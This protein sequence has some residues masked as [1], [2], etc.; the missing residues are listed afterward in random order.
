MSTVRLAMLFLALG[1]AFL[2]CSLESAISADEPERKINP[3]VYRPPARP[4]LPAVRAAAWAA[5][6][7]DC[8]ILAKLEAQGLAPSPRADKRTL[9]RRVTVDLTGLP[10]TA[11]EQEEFLAD[12][13]PDAYERVVDRLLSSPRYGERWAQHWLDL[14]R[15]AE[16][17][18]FKAD[19]LRLNAFRYRD[20]VIRALNAD[21][22]YDRFLRQQLAGDELEPGN[23]DAIVATGYNRLWPDEYNSATLELRHQVFARAHGCE[24]GLETEIVLLRKWIELVIVA[25]RAAHGQPQK[26]QPGHFRHV[27][28][29]LLMAQ[30]QRRGVVFIGP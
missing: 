3:W 8:F 11:A 26:R 19:E 24:E 1:S 13:R 12:D 17:D 5:N 22:P 7:I 16:T 29:S 10:P 15:Y 14:V 30:F 21:I 9:L 6:P 4:A 18:G 28:E 2:C 25:P 23:S 20:Y 27:V